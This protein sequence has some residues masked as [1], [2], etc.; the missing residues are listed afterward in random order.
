MA[1]LLGV[2]TI[3]Q[4]VDSLAGR[5]VGNKDLKESNIHDEQ[6]ALR[7]SVAGEFAKS[8]QTWWDSLVDGLNRLVRPLFTFGI[9]G[10]F[11]W[12]VVDPI[13]F[14]VAMTALQLIPD[15]LWIVIG[16]IIAFW[17][18]TRTLEIRAKAKSPVEVRQVIQTMEELSHLKARN[19]MKEAEYDE[20]M[21]NT[22][23]PMGEDAIAEWNRRNNPNY[24]RN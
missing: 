24:A 14:S 17:F 16:T 2:G 23:T 4:A 9:A 11:I 3:L 22:S 20:V 18:G 5:F 15:A 19:R 1:G 7:D 6:I 10:L 13:E 12:C 21:A 8:G